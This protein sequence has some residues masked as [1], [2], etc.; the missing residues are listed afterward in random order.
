L[1][2]ASKSPR[3]H[4][5]VP[6][7]PAAVALALVLVLVSGSAAA[8]SGSG[9]VWLDYETGSALSSETGKPF[10]VNFT[11]DWCKYCKKMK[12]ET[13]SD[14][15]VQAYLREH[16]VTALVDTEKHPNIAQKYYVRSLPTIWFL[17]SA[18]EP[19]TN[20]PGFVDA[21]TFLLVLAFIAEEAYKTQSFEE[22]MNAAGG[23]ATEGQGG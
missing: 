9:I 17:N 16:Y 22:F 5:D 20:L 15:A 3:R 8:G 1:A 23:G 4:G 6:R 10:M 2:P 13:Y 11:A 12:A 21:P 19:V 7:L 14:A 18:G